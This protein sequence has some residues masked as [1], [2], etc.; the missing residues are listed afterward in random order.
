[1]TAYTKRLQQLL[2]NPNMPDPTYQA[3][4]Q[5]IDVSDATLQKLKDCGALK[6]TRPP[7]KPL[8]TEPSFHNNTVNPIFVR[9]NW[10]P[11]HFTDEQWR[12]CLPAF[13]LASCFLWEHTCLFHYFVR[14]THAN[15]VLVK[16]GSRFQLE[17][18]DITLDKITQ[19]RDILRRMAEVTRFF[20]L[21]GFGDIPDCGARV[22]IIDR[23]NELFSA[24][25]PNKRKAFEDLGLG[26]DP[27]P[28]SGHIAIRVHQDLIKAIVDAGN[29]LDYKHRTC[30]SLAKTLVHEISHGLWRYVRCIKCFR[31]IRHYEP[32]V[33]GLARPIKHKHKHE[34]GWQ[35]ELAT[36]D[37][38]L[39][40]PWTM[41]KFNLVGENSLTFLPYGLVRDRTQPNVTLLHM[42]YISRWFE[43]ELWYN[44]RETGY[45][46]RPAIKTAC[47]IALWRN[48]KTEDR[49]DLIFQVEASG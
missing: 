44:L 48:L 37:G 30:F 11:Q 46:A 47:R 42:D 28:Q 29:D 32:Y 40:H 13:H 27:F 36:Y 23:R 38:I 33:T 25:P 19:T 7:G 20:T 24:F 2:P 4:K 35:W 3:P 39:S 45:T 18:I 31:H 14:L 41:L 10:H 22:S 8:I 34:L 21:Q 1:M 9:E 6:S 15:P 5:Y 17:N 49:W 12:V 16:D 26:H 43:Q